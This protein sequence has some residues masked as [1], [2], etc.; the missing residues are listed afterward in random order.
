MSFQVG[1][2][3]LGGTVFF[4]MGLRTPLRT[5]IVNAS[6]NTKRVSLSNQKYE[7]QLTF[8]DLHPNECS[9]EFYYYLFTV[10]S[11]KCIG[12]CNT[13]NDLSNKLCVLNKTDNLNLHRFNMITGINE[14]KSIYHVNVNVNLMEEIVI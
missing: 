3:S 7:I 1:I 14:W 8:I 12:S 5:M 9:Q 10:K 13:F 4:Q 6:N 11:D 2:G